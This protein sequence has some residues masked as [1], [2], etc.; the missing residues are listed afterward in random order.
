M[1]CTTVCVSVTP[2]LF[3]LRHRF[4]P[5]AKLEP[6]E[7][8][9]GIFFLNFCLLTCAGSVPSGEAGSRLSC[10]DSADPSACVA[11]I[12]F[13]SALLQDRRLTRAPSAAPYSH[14]IG[15]NFMKTNSNNVTRTP[16]H[17]LHRSTADHILALFLF[18]LAAGEPHML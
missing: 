8:F 3:P 4:L 14:R 18:A 11:R 17:F 9:C 15:T 6:L 1:P 10:A 5:R 12:V 16:K 7:G 2:F 13:P